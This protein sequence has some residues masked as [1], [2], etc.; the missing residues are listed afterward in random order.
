MPV[1][2][3]GLVPDI[4]GSLNLEERAIGPAYRG[5]AIIALPFCFQEIADYVP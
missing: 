4:D 5:K 3:E 1:V 2:P